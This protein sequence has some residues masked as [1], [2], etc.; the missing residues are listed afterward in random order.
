MSWA[1]VDEDARLSPRSSYAASKLAQEH[2][3]LAWSRQLPGSVVALRYHNVYGPGMPRNTP[4]SGVAA[5][6]R[7]LARARRAAHRVR[8]RRADARLRARRRRGA[9]EPP[10]G[11]AG[12]LGGRRLFE[13]FNVCSGRPVRILDVAEAIAAGTDRDDLAAAGLR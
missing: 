10:G 11:R 9:G 6:F 2:Y 7:S 5:M 4:Y 8:G 12:G 13:A 3:A 1:L